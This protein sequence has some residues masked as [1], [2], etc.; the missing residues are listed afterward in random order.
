MHGDHQMKNRATPI[1]EMRIPNRVY[2]HSTIRTR[3]SNL[4]PFE[5]RNSAFEIFP[6][7]T[8]DA[9]VSTFL[10]GREREVS[11]FSYVTKNSTPRAVYARKWGQRKWGQGANLDRMARVFLGVLAVKLHLIVPS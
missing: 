7:T 5:I 2:A 6:A 1:D 4:G 3:H 9:I 10:G 8:K 11:H